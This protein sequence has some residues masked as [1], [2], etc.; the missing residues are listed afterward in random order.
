MIREARP[1]KGFALLTGFRHARAAGAEY[2]V[3]VDGD[4]T[5]P[6]EDAPRLLEAAQDGA[7]MVIGTRLATFEEGAFRAG[8]SSATSSSSPSC[9]CSSG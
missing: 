9:A 6:A 7:E 4:D 1:G 2:F 8:H 5:Y 3:M